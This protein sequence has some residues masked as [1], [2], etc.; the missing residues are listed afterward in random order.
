MKVTINARQMTVRDSLKELV[1]DKLEKLDK[2]FQREGEATVTFSRKRNKENLEVTISAANTLFR[3]EVEDETFQNALDRAIDMIERQI[4][5]NKTRLEKRLREDAF[6]VPYDFH[7]DFEEE[8]EFKVRHKSFT[9]KPMSV[10][11]AILQ[12]NL[13]DHTFF[14]FKDAET[15]EVCVVYKRKDG[16]YGLISPDK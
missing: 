6:E 1:F 2:Y 5:K 8:P 4:R 13:L 11:E 9:Y 12:M 10:D 15:E 7:G 3:C 14:V 16:D